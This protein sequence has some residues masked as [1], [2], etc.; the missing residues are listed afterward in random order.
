MSAIKHKAMNAVIWSGVEGLSGQLIRFVI[1]VILARLL[2][3]AEF[4]LIG[5]L[6]IF[7]GVAQVF[8]NCGFGEGLIQ[9]QNTSYR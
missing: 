4:G 3:P 8:V 2:L 6:G 5:M 7:M 1:G 9:K